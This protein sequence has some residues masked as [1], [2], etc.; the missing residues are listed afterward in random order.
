MRNA[1]SVALL[2]A[3]LALVACAPREEAAAPAPPSELDELATLVQD[4]MR[5]GRVPGAAFALV[6]KGELVGVRGLGLAD[7]SSGAPVTEETVFEA[8]SLS[9]P[10]FAYLVAKRVERGELDLDRPLAETLPHPDLD[11]PRREKVTARQ[12]L[13]H[14]TGLPNWRPRRWTDDPGP[15]ALGFD[16]G[17]RFSYSG[18]G[19]EYL[20]MVVEH[21]TGT[22]LEELAAREVFSPLGMSSSGFRNP[23][24]PT[25][26]MPHDLLGKTGD[27]REPEAN[28]AGSLHT[29][30]G[31]YARFVIELLGPSHLGAEAAAALLAPQVEVETD[32]ETGVSWGLGWGLEPA[33]GTFWH[34]GDN[35]D[36][37]CF[38]RASRDS[39]DALVLFTNSRNGLAIAPEIF[40]HVFGA[41]GPAIAWIDYDRYDSPRFAIRDRLTRAGSE[42]GAEDVAAAFVELEASHSGEIAENLV[43]QIGYDL[44]GREHIEAAI[45]VF[46][47]NTRT[48]PDS[49][50][51]HDS[52]GEALAK[53]GDVAAAIES[54]EKSLELHPENQ[55][56]AD[57]LAELRRKLQG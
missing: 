42:G 25:V 2:A 36:F 23:G 9:K 35:G 8:A 5:K 6:R 34:W 55:N 19:F 48:Y 30:A 31:D 15:L 13:S 47:W 56:G 21:Q 28:A 53:S 54:Y 18:E 49:W 57:M 26:A 50:N 3:A 14:T 4:L 45:A 10:V 32:E 27:K 52:L 51:V 29:T 24:T 39:G 37:R 16:P 17:A 20:R 38:V 40:A 7:A 44:L 41:E 33:A 11:D 12:V 1:L 46:R 43:N 22:S